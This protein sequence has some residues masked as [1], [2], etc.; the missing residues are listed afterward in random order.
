M[1]VT[2]SR[3]V[4]A[5]LVLISFVGSTVSNARRFVLAGLNEVS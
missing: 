2:P 5:G 1:R 3:I 4:L